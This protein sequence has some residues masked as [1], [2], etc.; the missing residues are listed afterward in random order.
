MFF[1]FR[2][3][4]MSHMLG[5][6]ILFREVIDIFFTIKVF[7]TALTIS[8]ETESDDIVERIELMSVEFI[9][10]KWINHF[11]WIEINFWALERNDNSLTNKVCVSIFLRDLSFFL[12]HFFLKSNWI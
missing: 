4:E 7:Q 3:M 11:P 1:V 12:F 2:D 8:C 10:S 9:F 5:D 6:T